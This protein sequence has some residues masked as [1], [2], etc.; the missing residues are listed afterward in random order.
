MAYKFCRVE[1][2]EYL[3][4][5]HLSDTNIGFDNIHMYKT[6]KHDRVLDTI[7]MSSYSFRKLIL[8]PLIVYTITDSSLYHM[9]EL[10]D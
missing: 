9:F 6:I 5:M 7:L 3:M 1:E 4:C 8:I 10:Y 2:R